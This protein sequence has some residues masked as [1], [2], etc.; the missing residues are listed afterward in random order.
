MAWGIYSG[1]GTGG[2]KS[3]SGLGGGSTPFTPRIAPDAGLP[4]FSPM[5]TSSGSPFG[6][7]LG[8][9]FS[10][11][12]RSARGGGGNW[13]Y[14]ALGGAG[15]GVFGGMGG[16]GGGMGGG[17][18]PGVGGGMML[19]PRRNAMGGGNLYDPAGPVT[20][21]PFLRQLLGL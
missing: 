2:Q 17:G 12:A 3:S 8:F 9:A 6:V 4:V 20:F 10:P 14:Q 13:L 19:S 7:G 1:G 16:A 11:L 21:N 18:G 5:P 15:G